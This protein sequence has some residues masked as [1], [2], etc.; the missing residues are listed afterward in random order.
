MN[1]KIFKSRIYPVCAI[2]FLLMFVSC[3]RQVKLTVIGE[4]SSN[5]QAM[6][7]LKS[8]YEQDNNV[9][10]AFRP[11]T[12]EDALNKAN[13]DFIHKTGLYDIVLQLNFA[14]SSYVRNEFVYC[15]DDLLEMIEQPD[16]SFENNLF[17]NAW[18][19]VGWYKDLSKPNSNEIKKIG[20]P[21]ATNTMLLTYNK[22][23]FENPNNQKDYKAKYK[24][25]L[26]VPTTWE[27]F[28]NVAEFFTNQ[29]T[30]TYGV[31]MQGATDGWLYYE[32]CNFLFG[33]NGSV[34]DKQEK[35]RGWEG[36]EYTKITITSQEAVAATKLYKSLKPFNKGNYTTVDG[37]EQMKLL[38]EG[39]VAMGIVWS[40]YLYSFDV[41]GKD[42]GFAPI[43]GDK[44][45]IAGG[46][47][48][49]NKNTQN[50]KEAIKY[51]MYL[52]QPNVQIDLAKK[53][54]CS[55]LKTTYDNPD[56]Q[57]IAYSNALK[58]SLERGVYMFEASVESGVV[59]EVITN[60]I[61]RL[62][63][64]DNL[65]V[66]DILEQIKQ[67]IETGRKEAYKNQ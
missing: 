45:P 57:K 7:A 3:Q 10:I 12:F 6:E 9:K 44:S 11:N 59:S 25:D 29:N 19:E 17:Q 53:G 27:Q 16:T 40:D 2:A 24:E 15:I 46:C 58:T 23:M 26:T 65:K 66:E 4:D 36:T 54:L 63:N 13:Q 30:N 37:A 21:F 5:L 60:H 18:K 33:M 31:C 49:V 14:L 52:L 8:V 41:F 50:P 35:E 1:V 43:P 20:Y 22:K 34:F 64:N 61:Q 62:W 47:F 48:Y 42:F 67:D 38:K 28:R 55:P 51:I 32:Y 56:V 39:N